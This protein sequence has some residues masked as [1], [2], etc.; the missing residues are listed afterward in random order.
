MGAQGAGIRA[1]GASKRTDTT[2]IAFVERTRESMSKESMKKE[3]MSKD[4]ITGPL[5]NVDISLDAFD[6]LRDQARTY[7]A[8]EEVAQLV[9]AYNFAKNAH[10]G[11]IRKTGRVLTITG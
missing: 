2:R 4:P 8:K 10:E 6:Q 3:S 11:Q 7:M 1:T 5:E 9:K